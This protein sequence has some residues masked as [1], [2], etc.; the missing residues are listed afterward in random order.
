MQDP[1]TSAMEAVEE[2][3]PAKPHM[4][5]GG[6]A[7]MPAYLRKAIADSVQADLADPAKSAANAWLMDRHSPSVPT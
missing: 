3:A 7:E 6:P 5:R 1:D 4:V 2:A